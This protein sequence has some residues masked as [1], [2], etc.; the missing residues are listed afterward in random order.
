MSDWNDTIIAEFRAN[1]G[2]VGGQFADAPLLLL[3]TVGA[4][5]GQ[6]RVNPMMYQKVDDGYAVFAS[7]AGAPTNPDWYHNLLTHPQVQAEIGTNTVELVA[8]VTTGDERERIW[9]AQKAAYPGFADYERKTSRQIP[10]V[11]LEPAP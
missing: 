1:G 4:K 7:K 10:V 6:P 8:R 2:Q 5:S 9:S 3:H 11:V